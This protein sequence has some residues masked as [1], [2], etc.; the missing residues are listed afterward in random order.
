MLATAGVRKRQLWQGTGHRNCNLSLNCQLRKTIK[1]QKRVASQFFWW[2]V[3][4]WECRSYFITSHQPLG[5]H[6][7]A[8]INR[9][10]CPG[11]P[12]SEAPWP[13]GP[14]HRSRSRESSS[15]VVLIWNPHWQARANL[16]IWC[17]TL[18]NGLNL[19]SSVSLL[20]IVL[21]C[22]HLFLNWPHLCGQHHLLK[23]SPSSQVTVAEG[24]CATTSED[25]SEEEFKLTCFCCECRQVSS[26]RGFWGKTEDFRHL[27]V[28][29]IMSSGGGMQGLNPWPRDLCAAGK[30]PFP[31]SQESSCRGCLKGA[32]IISWIS[33]RRNGNSLGP[34]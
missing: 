32:M 11:V 6:F 12:R 18:S 22:I 33:Y 1:E 31:F 4:K 24:L 15:D 5:S 7:L 25:V 19:K 17:V 34:N 9:Y 13:G 27:L 2:I 14:R 16:C 26:S 30:K 28:T 10:F 21:Y 8:F 29:F 3:G 20:S 23:V